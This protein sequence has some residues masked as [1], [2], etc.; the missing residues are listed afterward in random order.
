MSHTER[1][2]Q[3]PLA[4]DAIHR[5]V[6]T[7][8]FHSEF[9]V[10][11]KNSVT[12]ALSACQ[13]SPCGPVDVLLC[14]GR[15]PRYTR[16]AYRHIRADNADDILIA[17][18][19][20]ARVVVSQ[21]G[22]TEQVGS[23]GFVCLASARPLYAIT[24]APDLRDWF[25]LYLVRIPAPLI[26]KLVPE[27]DDYCN[28]LIDAKNGAGKIML[29]LFE[30][31]IAEGPVLSENQARRFGTML[32]DAVANAT[33]EAPEVAEARA[34]KPES[35]GAKIY[36][37][38]RIYIESHLSKA[39]LSAQEIAEHCGASRRYV[40]LAFAA[41]AQSTGKLFERP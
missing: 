7:E 31:A 34:R 40:H 20:K 39:T 8:R 4:P 24:S 13:V 16:R 11:P 21:R 29:K 3:G 38:A 12:P 18:P 23:D 17:A 30:Q 14:E 25:S 28:R 10:N 22:I 1:H 37:S 19:L 6:N 32:I 15:G 27:I 36:A 41:R 9:R 5:L 2:Q 33:M 35:G 26:R